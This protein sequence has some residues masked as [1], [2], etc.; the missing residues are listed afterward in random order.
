[1]FAV[2]R[3]RAYRD[4]YTRGRNDRSAFDDEAFPVTDYARIYDTQADAYDAL[5]AREDHAGNLLA[6]LR[7]VLPLQGADVVETGAGTGRVTRM[8]A[9]LVRSV[10]AFERAEAMLNV[11]RQRIADDGVHNV[12]LGLASHA[13]LP[14]EDATADIALEGWAFG[15]AVSWN[16]TGWRDEVAAHV[17]EL[18]RTLRPG[19]TVVLIETMGTGVETPFAGGHGLEPFHA[20]V[21]ESLGFSHR[22]LRT[23]YRFE[24]PEEAVRLLGGFFGE[25]MAGRV[26]AAGATVWPEC[27]GLYWRR[28]V[29]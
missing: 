23:D 1:V 25:G 19:G 11:A 4:G 7:E 12:T 13:K 18:A 15:H 22:V 24:S 29:P 2:E 26:R 17:A 14:V 28:G 16:P 10:R 3:G 20:F 5:V 8:L 27:T 6:A 9:P 21:L